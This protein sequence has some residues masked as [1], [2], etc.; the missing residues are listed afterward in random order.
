VTDGGSAILQ[1]TLE[2]MVLK[3]L[4]AHAAINS[5]R[6]SNKSVRLYAASVLSLSECASAA[7]LSASLAIGEA[8]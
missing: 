7:S 5:R 6:R 1:G 8:G 4:E 2:L 3:T